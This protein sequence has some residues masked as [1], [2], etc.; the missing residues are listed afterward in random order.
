M[1]STTEPNDGGNIFKRLRTLA[2]LSQAEASA[3]VGVSIPTVRAWE[4]GKA[5][6]QES[7]LVILKVHLLIQ[8]KIDVQMPD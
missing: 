2:S 8:G 5:R 1:N 3:L 6:V 7:A 4:A